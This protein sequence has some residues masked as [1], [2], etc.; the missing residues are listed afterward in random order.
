MLSLAGETAAFDGVGEGSGWAA[1][2]TVDIR[3]DL[4]VVLAVAPTA[5]AKP[6]RDK[7][8]AHASANALMA[9]FLKCLDIILSSGDCLL[10]ELRHALARN[11]CN[12]HSKRA[13]HYAAVQLVVK[14][15]KAGTPFRRMALMMR[16]AT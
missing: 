6:L 5:N 16:G 15:N 11:A 1:S 8:P 13:P 3:G 9:T 4:P 7:P 14:V 2:T 10:V 12:E